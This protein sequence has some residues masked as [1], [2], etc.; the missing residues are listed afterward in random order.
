[1]V[2]DENPCRWDR[3]LGLLRLHIRQCR[4]VLS[5][6]STQNRPWSTVLALHRGVLRRK[7][8]QTAA[9][10]MPCRNFQ[11]TF[12]AYILEI[13]GLSMCPDSSICLSRLDGVIVASYCYPYS[14]F[15]KSS[16]FYT[17][18]KLAN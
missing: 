8:L 7:G 18:V 10:R 2:L 11:Y 13:S 16:Q 9:Q 15:L 5:I 3:I 6:P 12:S 1:M 17:S 4:H 14:L